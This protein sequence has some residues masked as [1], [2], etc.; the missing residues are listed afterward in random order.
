MNPF[1]RGAYANLLAPLMEHPG[2]WQ[3]AAEYPTPRIAYS[4]AYRLRRGITARPDGAWEFRGHR[5]DDGTSVLYA[6][7]LGGGERPAPPLPRRFPARPMPRLLAL[8]I[9]DGRSFT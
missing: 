7:Y 6:R 9:T 8:H 3:P 2:E 5:R 1:A 4:R